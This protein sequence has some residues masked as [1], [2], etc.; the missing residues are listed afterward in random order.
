MLILNENNKEID[1]FDA[2]ETMYSTF[3]TTF[4]GDGDNFISKRDLGYGTVYGYS[5]GKCE[6]NLGNE[7]NS[8]KN[9]SYFS[10]PVYNEDIKIT[11][12]D[13]VFLVFR[14]GFIGQEVIGRLGIFDVNADKN[15]HLSY[16]DGCSDSLLV[17]PPRKGDPT[18]NYLYFPEGITQSPHTHPSIRV[19]IVIDGE[20][21][22]ILKNETLPLVKGTSFLL[23]SHE[24]HSFNTDEDKTMSIIAY[25]PDG[26]WGP[27]DENHTML[28]R[29]YIK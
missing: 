2:R 12:D 19:G 5:M 14:L 21:M 26:D 6:I 23:N 27:T 9:D 1:T 17:Y 25:H 22:A 3:S 16:I 11:H 4:Y 10:F 15:G 13:T 29:T 8:I 24:L 7:W 18:L 28:N 20:G